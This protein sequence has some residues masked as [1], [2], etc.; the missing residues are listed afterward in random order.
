MKNN[1]QLILGITTGIMLGLLISQKKV[2]ELKVKYKENYDNF[3]SENGPI[4]KEMIVKYVNEKRK[5]K[6][7][8]EGDEKAVVSNS[9]IELPGEEAKQAFENGATCLPLE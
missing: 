2:Y 9:A 6:M 4:S 7:L 5:N 1:T 3:I 8:I